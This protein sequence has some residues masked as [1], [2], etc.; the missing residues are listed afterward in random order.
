VA[1]PEARPQKSAKTLGLL[2]DW[3]DE[4]YQET[5]RQT[6][7]DAVH[8]RGANL[9]SFAGGIPGSLTRNSHKRH[10]VFDLVHPT[11]VDGAILLAG[12]MVNELGTSGLEDLLANLRGLPLCSIGVELK[13]VPSILVDNQMGIDRALTHLVEHH[14][15]KRIAFI[16]GPA[17]N[18]EAESRFAAYQEGLAR[19]DLKKDAALVFQ[20]DFLSASG[21]AAVAHWLKT[22][23]VPDAIIA[24]NDEM[25]LGALAALTNAGLSVP[26][27]VK[28]V[29]FDDL[30]HSRLSTPP[31]TTVRQ[32][33]KDLAI[34]AVRTIMDQLNGR[35]VPQLQI[36]QTQL[37]LRE[38]CGCSL[39]LSASGQ[40][41]F[42]E[43]TLEGNVDFE[44]A[45]AARQWA[46]RAEMAR[47]A[48]GEFHSLGPWEDELIRSFQDT[49][50]SG[51]PRFTEELS[52]RI[53][54]VANAG[55]ELSRWHDII[56]AFRR[57]AVPST[58]SDHVLRE[59]CED[60]LHEARL[61]ASQAVE[62]AEARKRLTASR[63]TRSLQEAGSSIASASSAD[64][65]DIAL[66]THL[67]RLG[68]SA[69]YVSA[70]SPNVAVGTPLPNDAYLLSAS[71]DIATS[72]TPKP[73]DSHPP[74]PS[75]TPTYPVFP[76]RDLVPRGV[77]TNKRLFRLTLVPLFLHDE[78]L[79]FAMLD[80]H[81]VE[82]SVVEA[83]RASLSLALS[84]CTLR[85]QVHKGS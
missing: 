60:V 46:L 45:F 29:G 7:E 81:G 55:G 67:P 12:T 36:L 8:Q 33:V 49:I 24:A 70:Y 80:S 3:F 48:R 72:Q 50:T 16:R 74:P 23:T 9:L 51:Q 56:T 11:N 69:W 38:S 41:Q 61:I 27:D 2:A 4:H 1:T 75:S 58:S 62:R 5:I 26:S 44:T 18:K 37:I 13:D 83:L 28:L 66:H 30:E 63:Y 20:G 22:R 65:L 14:G 19:L 76:L 64:A 31:I 10:A 82:G 53:A 84:S 47:V 85:Q 32:P 34:A 59:R 35:D 25:A 42:P 17:K 73:H 21:E 15:C 57:V 71:A 77:R 79:G 39:R 52:R 54:Q 68:I 43:P 78:Q 6:A 40:S